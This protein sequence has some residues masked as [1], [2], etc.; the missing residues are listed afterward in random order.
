MGTL[1]FRGPRAS[2][3]GAMEPP[4]VATNLTPNPASGNLT[5]DG[6]EQTLAGATA[7]AGC[8]VLEVNA[9]NMA[10]LDTVIL[11]AYTKTYSSDTRAL[12]FIASF[13]NVQ[14]EKIKIS[15]MIYAEG[16]INFTLQQTA[17]TNRTYR[18]AVLKV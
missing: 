8:Y 2:A 12:C 14:V 16:D 4:E 6:S 3:A 1:I 7:A 13:S 10:N 11:R 18:W 5:A 17:G 9:V 15:P